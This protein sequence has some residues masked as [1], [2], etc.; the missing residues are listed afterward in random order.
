MP[1]SEDDV[2]A[3]LLRAD[4]IQRAA[5]RGANEAEIQRFI[6]R[7]EA[8]GYSKAAVLQ[9]LRERFGVAAA[10]VATGD[11]VFARS[12]DG[13]YHVA[14]VV[15]NAPGETRVRYLRGTEQ[16]LPSDEVRPFVLAPGERVSVNWPMWGPWSC[17]L[18]YYDEANGVVTLSDRWGS[19]KT[20]PIA[21]IWIEPPRTEP[22]FG[23]FLMWAAV[24]GSGAVIGGI[25][26]TI[27]SR[28][29]Q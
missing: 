12:S 21:E 29:I 4:Q 1:L 22:G 8:S 15:S 7:A 18:L 19:E 11:R 5:V 20:F 24:L 13:K 26:T 9:A 23:S 10:P 28:I 27:I 3:V 25:L 2:N 6:E 17:E 16:S 14:T